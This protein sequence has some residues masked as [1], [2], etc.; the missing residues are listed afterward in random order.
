MMEPDTSVPESKRRKVEEEKKN[1]QELYSQRY[2]N[3]TKIIKTFEGYGDF[4]GVVDSFHSKEGW[5]H[6]IYVDGD[7]EELTERELAPLV[8]TMAT[9]AKR[10]KHPSKKTKRKTPHSDSEEPG[11]DDSLESLPRKKTVK[12][13]NTNKPTKRLLPLERVTTMTCQNTLGQRRR[14]KSVRNLHHANRLLMMM[15]TTSPSTC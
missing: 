12:G 13:K 1:D 5:Y 11:D 14:L 7:D 8:V 4:E 10:K 15:T 9:N 6:V 3:G 2:P